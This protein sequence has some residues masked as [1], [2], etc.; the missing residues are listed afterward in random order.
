MKQQLITI[1]L[2]GVFSSQLCLAQVTKTESNSKESVKTHEITIQ[3]KSDKDTKLVI[4]IKSDSV[5]INGK[6]LASFNEDGIVIGTKKMIIANELRYDIGSD[7]NNSFLQDLDPR[8]IESVNIFGK[9]DQKT[10]EVTRK[11]KPVTYL[12]VITETDDEGLQITTVSD[13]SPA[14]MAGL[15]QE[16]II[17]AIDNEKVKTPE[18]LTKIIRSKKAGD[19]ITIRFKRDGKQMKEDVVL[20]ERGL[21]AME[22]QIKINM[23]DGKSKVYTMPNM[24]WGEWN[25]R[26]GD[27]GKNY[28]YDLYNDFP[29]SK[30][31]ITINGFG[32]RPKLGLKIQDTQ[33]E[34]GV[35]V[36]EVEKESIA[37]KAGLKA[38]DVIVAIDGTDVKNTDIF[39]A[40]ST[41][42]SMKGKYELK[43]MR[44]GK[45]ILANIEIPKKL[46]TVEL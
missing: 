15:Q 33:D 27:I 38:N 29:N 41:A 2:G 31:R 43:L 10:V 11:G 19:K 23:P 3:K 22:R 12:G 20:K 8:D 4:E 32:N 42:A 26:Y 46:K 16:D 28:K 34:S 21:N 35:K 36:L 18:A 6:P 14:K 45:Q 9:G 40:K 17:T 7:L 44:D 13:S 39:R 24:N 25:Y 1:F 30:N 5:I 37:E